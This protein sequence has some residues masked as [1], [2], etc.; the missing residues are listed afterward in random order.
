MDI[1]TI[2]IDRDMAHVILSAFSIASFEGMSSL[3]ALAKNPK[4]KPIGS[5]FA[6]AEANV[7]KTLNTIYPDIVAQYF[8]IKKN[9]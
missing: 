9:A 4:D 7:L 5:D 2:P 8:D 1:D 3:N 6:Q